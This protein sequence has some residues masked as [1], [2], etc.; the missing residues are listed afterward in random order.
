MAADKKIAAE[1]LLVPVLVMAFTLA[2]LFAFQMTQIMRD[3]TA[4]QQT[5]ER[6]EEPLRNA[7]K[8][9]KQFGGLVVGTRKLAAEGSKGAQILVERLKQVG[10]IMPAE[11]EGEG[12]ASPAPVPAA[13]TPTVP[14]PVKP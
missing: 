10:I 12:S 7:Q 4:L 5:I 11:G 2:L 13:K 14:G 9:T 3:R 8:L 6:Q 1:Q